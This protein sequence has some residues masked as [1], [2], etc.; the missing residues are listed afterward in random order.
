MRLLLLLL[1]CVS[2]AFGVIVP[3]SST[4]PVIANGDYSLPWQ[5][6]GSKFIY[7]VSGTFGGGTATLGYVNPFGTF[8]A[9]TSPIGSAYAFTASGSATVFL[10]TGTVDGQGLF[11]VTL[12]GAT[13][14]SLTLTLTKIRDGES[15]D[16]SD[17]VGLGTAAVTAASAYATA[18]QGALAD[19]ALQAASIKGVIVIDKTG[20][21]TPY[22]ASA[23]TDTARGVAYA[24]AH[25]AAIQL[26]APTIICSPGGYYMA[27]ATSTIAGLVG[28]FAIV[29]GMTIYLNGA[30]FWKQNTDTASVMFN[31]NA[32][33]GINDWSIIGPGT[34]EGSYADTSNTTGARG[35]AAAEM[36]INVAACRRWKIWGITIKNMAGTGIQCNSATF[37]ADGYATG[38]KISTGHV[39]D[40]HIDFNNIGIAQYQSNEYVTWSNCTFNKNQTAFDCYGGNWKFIGCEFSL[41]VNYVFRLRGTSGSNYGHGR[42][43]GCT[44]N[45]N[46]GY[47]VYAEA[48]MVN[49][50]IFS[51]CAFYSDSTSTNKI[52]SLGKGLTFVGCDM[53][54]PIY[55]GGTAAGLNSIK[56]CFMPGTLAAFDAGVSAAERAKW[57]CQNNHSTTGV[58]ASD[59]IMT[60]YTDDATA[61]T[62][63]VLAGEIWQQTTTG[64]VFVK[65]P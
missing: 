4:T 64:A 60:T 17:I 30:Y 32:T 22:P 50:W 52:E 49:G 14:P 63:G 29:D 42:C 19:T 2:S 53:D 48:G 10:P 34:I 65:L 6:A 27:Q 47:A 56:C 15:V 23:D 61:G 43:V 36:A 20:N 58:W 33:S 7:G 35:A 62:G 12:T 13:S 51:G 54:S 16:A 21:R 8:T 3:I 5:R 40:C 9:F 24:A 37:P 44:I 28:Q 1:A 46:P 26:T 25:A 41:N 55:A 59:D 45:H 57:K 31:P 18:A 11:A 39:T 38:N